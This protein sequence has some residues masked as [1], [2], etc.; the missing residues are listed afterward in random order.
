[1]HLNVASMHSR[2]SRPVRSVV[3]YN[4]LAAL[5]LYAWNERIG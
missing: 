4:L 2:E 5:G 3:P 1:M